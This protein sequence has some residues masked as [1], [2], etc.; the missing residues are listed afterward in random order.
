MKCEELKLFS[1]LEGI[2][3]DQERNEIEEHLKGC[4]N[5]REDLE[6]L[7]FAIEAFTQFYAYQSRRTCPSGEELISFEYGMMDEGPASRIRRHVDQCAGCQEDLRLIKGFEKQELTTWHEPVETPPLSEE[8]LARI[9]QLKERS[10][11]DRMEKVLQSLLAK[12]RAPIT[13][14]KIPELLDQ[15]FAR[16]PETTPAYAI[17][18]DATLSDTELTL[19]EFTMLTDITFDIGEY[20]VSVKGREDA[21]AVKVLK[22]KQPVNG[23]EVRVETESFGEFKGRTG[24]DGTCVIEGVPPGPCHLKVCIPGEDPQ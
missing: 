23:V 9:E 11:L 10:V 2:S 21:V 16:T 15:Y 3:S 13:A 24:T 22:A 6:Q 20:E 4:K 7:K 5:C 18:S 1:Y 19:R 17:P 8:I 12:G 14:D